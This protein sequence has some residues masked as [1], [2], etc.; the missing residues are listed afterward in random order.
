MTPQ[1]IA[2]ICERVYQSI[3][4][5]NPETVYAYNRACTLL[6]EN[7]Q[8]YFLTFETTE[9]VYKHAKRLS[10]KKI[11]FE[12]YCR[13]KGLSDRITALKQFG[14]NINRLYKKIVGGKFVIPEN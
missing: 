10:N 11:E 1:Y 2:T 6:E 13:Y 7:I 4:L 3:D 14:G 8:R 9:L 5:S 12:N